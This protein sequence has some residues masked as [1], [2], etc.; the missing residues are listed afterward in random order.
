MKYNI[1]ITEDEREIAELI[2]LYLENENY[3]VFCAEDGKEALEFLEQESIDMAILDIM[4]PGMDGYEL[5][6]QIRKRSNMPILI[7][8]AKTQSCDKI[9]GLNLGADDYMTK[10]FDPLE[11]VARVNSALRRFYHLNGEPESKNEN[12]ILKVGDLVLDTQTLALKK[13]DEEVFL[14]PMEYKILA[15]FMKNP[16]MIFTKVQIYENTCGEYVES[17]DNTIMVHIS[18]LREKIEENPYISHLIENIDHW[19]AFDILAFLGVRMIMESFKDEDC[20]HEFDPT[21]LKVVAALAVATSIDALAVGVSFAFLGVCNFASILPPIGI[22]GF[23]SFALSLA[24]L[25]FGIRCGCGIARKLRSELWG[26]IILI[27]IGTKILIEH[28]FF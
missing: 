9:R 16:G 23:V 6:K 22:I 10:P 4:M 7:L 28:L 13:R 18:N 5:T 15:L 21:K 20:R 26:G 14:T 19:I 17:D 25:M 2:K 3:R 11:V 24:G 27:V 12:H 8:S 1:L